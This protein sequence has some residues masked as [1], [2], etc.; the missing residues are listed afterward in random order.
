[1]SWGVIA[2]IATLGALAAAAVGV[3]VWRTQTAARALSAAHDERDLAKKEL[4]QL[5]E[6]HEAIQR[7]QDELQETLRVR[8]SERDLLRKQLADPDVSPIRVLFEEQRIKDACADLRPEAERIYGIWCSEYGPREIIAYFEQEYRELL[9]N[10]DLHIERIIN[11]SVVEDDAWQTFYDL[12]RRT[13]SDV[14]NRWIVRRNAE[15]RDVELMVV[16]Y[17]NRPSVGVVVVNDITTPPPLG[18]DPAFAVVL[19]PAK[20]P[21]LK[22]GVSFIQRMFNAYFNS[23]ASKALQPKHVGIWD[24]E[25]AQVY[26]RVIWRN[27]RLPPFFRA[28]KDRELTLLQSVLRDLIGAADGGSVSVVEIGCG[29]G[30][31]LLECAG[32]EFVGHVDHLVGFDASPGMIDEAVGNLDEWKDDPAYAP[33]LDLLKRMHFAHLDVEFMNRHFRDGELLASSSGALPGVEWRPPAHGVVEIA[34]FNRPQTARVFCCMLNTFGVF[35]DTDRPTFLRNMARALG[36]RDRLV[37]SVLDGRIFEAAAESFY[38][39]I[40]AVTRS[41]GRDDE[42]YDYANATFRVKG[43]DGY[44]S[45]WFYADSDSSP[46]GF[47]R[48][49]T[50]QDMLEQLVRSLR[51]H[52]RFE[53]EVTPIV[54]ESIGQ[55]AHF[56]TI[57]RVS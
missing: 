39:V 27:T 8:E 44:E 32:R 3:L 11:P 42:E 24:L 35:P 2:F 31:A 21:L 41:S 19:D 12:W 29:T 38:S 43:E 25:V 15:L 51:D 49:D 30:R 36:K 14:R 48:A 16:S 4:R 18:P 54:A 1:M 20:N 28:Y 50:L 56:I 46:D 47:P 34:Q 45:R 23:G 22:H 10:P 52:A 53:F 17:P 33:V 13:P 57:R 55:I 5:R 6:Q 37:I 26:D 7:T 9:D 40:R